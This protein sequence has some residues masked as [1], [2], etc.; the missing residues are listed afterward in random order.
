VLINALSFTLGGGRSYVHN[1]LRE[2]GRDARGFEFTVLVAEGQLAAE[3]AFGVPLATLRLPGEGSLRALLRV[4]YEEALLPVR[5]GAFDLLYCVADLSPAVA[6]TPT[7]VALR[8][9]NIYDRRFYDDART[10]T[11]YRCV[12]AGLRRCRR[13]ICPTRAAAERIA[14]TVGVPAERIT[15]VPHGVAPEAFLAQAE[16]P[17]AA[18]PYLFFSGAVERHKNIGVAIEALTVQCDPRLELW[19]AGTDRTDPGYAAEL[20]RLAARLGVAPRVR[21]LG[22]VPYREILGYYRGALALVFPS[23]IESFGHPLLEA[24]LAGT[25]VLAADIPTFHELAGEAALYFPPADAAALAGSVE[26]LRTEPEA[27]RGRVERGRERAAA[28][29]WRRS[30]DLLCGVLAGALAGP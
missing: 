13:I 4:L 24:M 14:P 15:V 26:R 10:R 20:R 16:P 30:V 29:S 6:R 3:E 8:N 17:P 5:A 9:L 27:A 12:R 2:L 7:V 1:L 18:S 25:P 28:F 23:L 19:I 21:F 22:A 11:L